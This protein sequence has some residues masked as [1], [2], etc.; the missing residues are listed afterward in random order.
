V[1][2]RNLKRQFGENNDSNTHLTSCI[3]IAKIKYELKL[4]FQVFC[5]IGGKKQHEECLFRPKYHYSLAFCFEAKH[6]F[7]SMFIDKVSSK[8]CH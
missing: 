2:N 5:Q 1:I 6:E 4:N 3:K 7:S 8:W